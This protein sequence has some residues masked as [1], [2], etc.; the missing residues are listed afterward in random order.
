MMNQLVNINLPSTAM[1]IDAV[2]TVNVDVN[3]YTRIGW[4]II[5]GGL[6]SFV[7]WAS[8]A[9]L[10]KG[11]P[12]SGIVTVATNKKAIQHE[13]GGTVEEILVKEGAVVQAGDVLI[14]MNNVQAG[15]DAETARVQ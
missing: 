11:V 3:K 14:R 6:G 2:S 10:D 4:W 13:T 8:L 7:L 5:L 12:L 9:P 15:S 1:D